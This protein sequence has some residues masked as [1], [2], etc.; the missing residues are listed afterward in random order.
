MLMAC[1]GDNGTFRKWVLED[2]RSLRG[3]FE[4]AVGT[5]APVILLLFASW[6]P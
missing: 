1:S 6:L 4:G 2:V 3:F 5:L